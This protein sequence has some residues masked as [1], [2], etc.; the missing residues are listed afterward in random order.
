MARSL[1]D[2][3][4]ADFNELSLLESQRAASTPWQHACEREAVPGASVYQPSRIC[5]F[6]TQTG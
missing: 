5:F 1:I 4:Y 2:I 6:H 3:S